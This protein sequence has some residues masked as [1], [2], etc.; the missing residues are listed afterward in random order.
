MGWVAA[1]ADVWG[2]SFTK[3]V[4]RIYDGADE[5]EDHPFVDIQKRPNSFQT[6]W[7]I[8]YRIAQNF[9]IY[10][11]SFL[12]KLRDRLGTPRALVQ[13]HPDRMDTKPYGKEQIDVYVYNALAPIEIPKEDIIHF[14]YPDP[15][16]YIKGR[17]VLNN[18]LNQLEIDKFQTAYQKKFYAE[19]GFYGATFSTDQKMTK[20]SF[21][22]MRD[23]LIANYGG[24]SDNAYKVALF[25]QGL[26]P[27]PAAYSIKDM[28]I[29]AQRQLTQQEICNAFQVNKLLLGESEL[30]QRGNADTVFYVFY[31]MVA[32]PLL[33][34]L[35][36]VFTSQ[37]MVTDF[38]E[39]YKVKHDELAS[40]DIELD[41]KYY[42]EGLTDGWLSPNEVREQEGFQPFDGGDII[43]RTGKA[44]PENIPADG[45]QAKIFNIG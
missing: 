7:E 32:D 14:R 18:V 12:L 24:G 45:E 22:R 30:I 36:E 8:K 41:L 25:E 3:G 40:K 26:K 11:N 6:W 38:S 17:P 35:D 39:D 27:I 31:S 42:H 23:E 20:E 21:S 5:I 2:K 10:G 19:G 15:D 43:E 16:N 34:Y 33:S 9:I 1:C 44:Q 29:A 13:L 37:L 28:D 4:F